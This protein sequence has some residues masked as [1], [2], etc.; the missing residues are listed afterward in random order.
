MAAM[1]LGSPC[2]AASARGALQVEVGAFDAAL[3]AQRDLDAHARQ[4]A[5]RAAFALDLDLG[6]HVALGG[7]QAAH[8]RRRGGFEAAQLALREGLAGGDDGQAGQV[9]V[10]FEQAPLLFG[11]GDGEQHLWWWR[12]C[13]AAIRLQG[14]AAPQQGEPCQSRDGQYSFH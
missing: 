14:R 10:G 8:L 9:E 4:L 13:V 1:A 6:V 3:R 5:R 7:E 11:G 2:A 12:R